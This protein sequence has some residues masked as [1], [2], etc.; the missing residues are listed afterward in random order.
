MC[1]ASAVC[2]IVRNEIKSIILNLINCTVSEKYTSI[3][4]FNRKS[5]F[6]YFEAIIVVVKDTLLKFVNTDCKYMYC[7][8]NGICV[9]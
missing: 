1:G 5:F 8:S 7:G 9:F 4:V 2:I 6:E 3:N